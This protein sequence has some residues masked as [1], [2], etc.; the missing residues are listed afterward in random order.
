MNPKSLERSAVQYDRQ[1]KHL[2][3][4]K[5]YDQIIKLGAA[6]KDTWFRTGH[7]LSALGEF[8]QAIGAFE[9]GLQWDNKNPEAHHGLARA[10]YKLGDIDAAARHLEIASEQCDSVIPWLSLATI[11]PGCPKFNAQKVLKIRKAFALKLRSCLPGRPSNHRFRMTKIPDRILRIGYLSAYFD[12]ANYMKPVWGLINHHD[13]SS[14]E[15]H[16]FSDTPLEK[17]MPGYVNHPKDHIHE[18]SGLDNHHLGALI[19]DCGIDILVDLNGYSS[20]ERLPLFLQ[21]RA[22][23][24]I[25]WFNMFATSG[26]PGIDYII[27]DHE[28]IKPK[29]ERFFCERVLRLPQSYLTFEVLEPVPAVSIPP[30][31]KNG[32]LTFGSL[33]SQYKITEPVL[34]AWA[35]ILNRTEKTR[36]IIGNAG[37][38]SPCNRDHLLDRFARRKV[39]PDR[40][41]LYGPADHFAFLKYYDLMDVALDPFPYNG[42]TTTMEAIWQGVPVLTFQGDRWAS[43]TSTSILQNTHLDK[44][45]AKNLKGYIDSAIALAIHPDSPKRLAELRREMRSKLPKS[46]ACDTVSLTKNMEKLYKRIWNRRKIYIDKIDMK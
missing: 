44:F 37:L 13:R 9:N 36:L 18:I 41:S 12:R 17:G 31:L 10:Y 35:E 7:A 2:K 20:R 29:E 3:A 26:L 32:F 6:T 23:I 33:S 5:L 28:V 39:D 8:A 1:G 27:G 21:R 40:I 25:A 34:D 43:R 4:L 14:F 45:V 16:L 30:C 15:I 38:N 19:R 42:G 11:A 46:P 24:V 22:P